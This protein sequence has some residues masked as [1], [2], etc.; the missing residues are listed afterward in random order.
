MYIAT[1]KLSVTINKGKKPGHFWK[2]KKSPSPDTILK[3]E[4][5]HMSRKTWM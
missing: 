3:P 2:I 1:D 5:E 4:K